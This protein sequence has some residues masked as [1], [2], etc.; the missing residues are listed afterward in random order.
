MRLTLKGC[1]N[2][3]GRREK[4]ERKMRKGFDNMIIYK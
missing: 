3:R 2:V 4:N 1:P